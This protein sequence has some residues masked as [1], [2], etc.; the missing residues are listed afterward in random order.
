LKLLEI[1][2][3]GQLGHDLVRLAGSRGWSADACGRARLDLADPDR[4]E[5]VVADSGSDAVVNCAAH[6][7][8]DRMERAP[9]PAFAVN[10]RAVGRL[11]EACRAADL[12]LV[13]VSTDYVFPGTSDR[14]YRE[15]DAP[16]PL[17]VYGAS[18][19]VGEE[20]A[21]R[22]HPGGAFVVRTASLFGRA[23]YRLGRPNFVETVLS[24][25][26]QKRPLRVVD[27]VVMSP[28]STADLA[29]GIMQLLDSGAD[30]GVY[31]MVNSGRATWYELARAV[32]EAG[33][34]AT[35][36]EPV[37]SAEYGGDA[38][39]PTFSVLA[40]GRAEGLGIRFASWEDALDR[41]M[42]ERAESGVSP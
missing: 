5:A 32:V 4:I 20:L 22:A 28:T 26:R 33:G 39:R 19:L 40:T 12:P 41:Y 13:Q 29:V 34:A 2:S 23:G 9:E 38:A 30:P 14:P 27:D 11:A 17:S 3:G 31:H 1:G 21:R 8:T 25:G 10:A 37:A 24:A 6:H 36:L 35:E 18:K 42:V 16:G 7:G 15:D